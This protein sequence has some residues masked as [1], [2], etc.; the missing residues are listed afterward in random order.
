[1]TKLRRSNVL[2]GLANV[3]LT[4]LKK[5]VISQVTRWSSTFAMLESFQ[6]DKGFCK[7]YADKKEFKV[8]NIHENTW[9][10]FKELV[11]MLEPIQLMTKRSQSQALTVTDTIYFWTEMRQ[12]LNEVRE[13]SAMPRIFQTLI[14]YIK[15]REPALTEN[16]IAVAG[17]YLG[18]HLQFTMD[19]DKINEAK[20]L[21]RMVTLK[22][23]ELVRSSSPQILKKMSASRNRNRTHKPKKMRIK[24]RHH[25]QRLS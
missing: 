19:A 21:I 23:Y 9:K 1:M 24:P 10:T 25:L 20:L 8:L 17:F 16:K 4:H 5:P 11:T 3:E 18:H 14:K 15:N 2:R 12:S 6:Q 22:R 7:K 13:K